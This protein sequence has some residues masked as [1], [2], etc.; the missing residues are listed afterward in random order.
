M[1]GNRKLPFGYQMEFGENVPQPA[2]AETVRWIF[3]AYLAGASYNALVAHLR[4]QDV[5]YDAGKLWNK[6]MVARIL[7]DRRYSGEAGYPPLLPEEQFKNAQARRKARAAPVKKTPTQT[8]LRRLCG[9]NPPPWVEKQVLL[10][11]NKLIQQPD[12]V[13]CVQP[14]DMETAAEISRVRRELEEALHTPPVD[15]ERTRALVFRAAELRLNAIGPEEYETMRLQ[16]LFRAHDPLTELEEGLLRE[17]VRQ[18]TYSGRTVRVLLKNNQT[19]EGGKH[20]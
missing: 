14:P 2:E 8:H 9:G 4:E 19:V 12:S 7:E 15:I 3:Q 13:T 10:L 11:I 6:N 5:P 18:I 16:R 1:A 20:T 17:T